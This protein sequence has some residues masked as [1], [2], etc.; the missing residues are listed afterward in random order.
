MCSPHIRGQTSFT[1]ALS[2]KM[3]Y[4]ILM[5]NEDL[6]SPP[7]TPSRHS[8]SSF[9]P[10]RNSAAH[11]DKRDAR[12][13]REQPWAAFIKPPLSRRCNGGGADLPDRPWKCARCW[14]QWN[15]R[16]AAGSLGKYCVFKVSN[17]TPEKKTRQVNRFSRKVG[18]FRAAPE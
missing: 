10:R 8:P 16:G 5:L 14:D 3:N 4:Q 13:C 2:K 6:A 17:T 1:A 11:H 12:R 18:V 15:L 9:R 7:I